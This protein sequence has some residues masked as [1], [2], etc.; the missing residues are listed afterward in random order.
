MLSSPWS[1]LGAIRGE[2]RFH[3]LHLAGLAHAGYV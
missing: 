3:N 2:S 1:G